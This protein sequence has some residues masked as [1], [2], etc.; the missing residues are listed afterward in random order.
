MSM[1]HEGF[2]NAWPFL[3]RA[4]ALE[5]VASEMG[6]VRRKMMLGKDVAMVMFSSSPPPLCRSVAVCI[7]TLKMGGQKGC[8]LITTRLTVEDLLV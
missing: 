4:I 6:L 8:F 7:S 1:I 3:H 5:K 2:A